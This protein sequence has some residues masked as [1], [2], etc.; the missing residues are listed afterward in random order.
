MVISLKLEL[1]KLL[2]QQR[3]S[4]TSAVYS[5]ML[6]TILTGYNRETEAECEAKTLLSLLLLET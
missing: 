5:T 1:G 4:Q 2:D 6:V 3:G